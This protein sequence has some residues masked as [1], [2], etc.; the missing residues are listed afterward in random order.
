M[1][2]IFSIEFEEAT[3]QAFW[4]LVKEKYKVRI[5]RE[6]GEGSC[7]CLGD[8]FKQGGRNQRECKHIKKA[9]ELLKAGGLSG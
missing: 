6:T 2:K 9:R 5:D 3:D 7:E 8:I 1:T 4:F